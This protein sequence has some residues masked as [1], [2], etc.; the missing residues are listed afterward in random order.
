MESIK[1]YIVYSVEYNAM[2][3]DGHF[4]FTL[5]LYFGILYILD[6]FTTEKL[7]IG[8]MAASLSSLPDIDIRLRIRHR[9]VTHSIFTGVIAGAIVG[10]IM[11]YFG[12]SYIYG[13]EV[14]TLAFTSHIIGDLFTYRPFKPLYPIYN[15]SIAF[16]LFRS[17]NKVINKSMM[18]IG[19]FTLVIYLF[20]LYGIDILSL[21]S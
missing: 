13:F 5:L 18:F 17:D 1:L 8:L 6:I 15:I 10:Y 2:D 4:G 11:Y 12:Y 9:G 19:S 3:R 21:I 14:V 7:V 20:R 16:K